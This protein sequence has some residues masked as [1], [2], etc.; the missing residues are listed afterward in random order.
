MNGAAVARAIRGD[1]AI[2]HTP[3]LLL[4]SVDQ[5]DAASFRGLNFQGQLSKPARSSLLLE[6][7][8]SIIL[9]ARH[10]AASKPVV[11]PVSTAD[12]ASI[13]SRRS[14]PAAVVA[15]VTEAPRPLTFASP[16]PRDIGEGQID[17]LVAEDNEV[18][19]I[20][21]TQALEQTPYSFKIVGNGRLALLHWR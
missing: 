9:S 20:V 16:R 14:E 6:T 7:I 5:F 21:F 15:P 18:N 8:T 2:K 3:L 12:A 1:D 13:P 10:S 4:S 17:I 19:Q 11:V